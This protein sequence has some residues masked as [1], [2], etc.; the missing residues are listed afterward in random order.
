MYKLVFLEQASADI[1]HYAE[2]IFE[3]TEHRSSV[4]EFFDSIKFTCDQIAAFPYSC[5]VYQPVR[6]LDF[7]F[8]VKAFG[9]YSLFYIVNE[10]DETIVVAR[11]VLTKSEERP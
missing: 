7:E 3:Y 1:D 5:P 6:S 10:A 9:N 2:K 11:I 4:K 8:R